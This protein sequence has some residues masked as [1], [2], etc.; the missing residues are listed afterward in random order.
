M[1][2]MS[3]IYGAEFIKTE[4]RVGVTFSKLAIQSRDSD[5]RLRNTEHA[6]RAYDVALHH[7]RATAITE[8][9]APEIR[10]LQAQLEANLS[11]LR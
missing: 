2:K 5:K 4:L 10:T 6:Q 9:S 1:L 3:E 7:L 11:L 8:E